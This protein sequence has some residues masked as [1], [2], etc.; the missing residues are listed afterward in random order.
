L[1]SVILIYFSRFFG[2]SFPSSPVARLGNRHVVRHQRATQRKNDVTVRRAVPGPAGALG[3]GARGV[4]QTD[5]EVAGV[6]TDRRGHVRRGTGRARGGQQDQE[7]PVHVLAGAEE[8]QRL[9]AA[10]PGPVRGRSRLFALRAQ[11]AL[12]LHIGLD[13]RRRCRQTPVLVTVHRRH[14]SEYNLPRR[15]MRPPYIFQV[16]NRTVAMPSSGIGKYNWRNILLIVGVKEMFM[17]N[18]TLIESF[19]EIEKR[20]F[21]VK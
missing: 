21:I 5:G 19:V 2:C 18:K 13:D 17:I 11:V 20:V 16:S 7:H 1:R 9:G 4:Q 10:A 15:V 12:V 14:A 3:Q 8:D 6:P